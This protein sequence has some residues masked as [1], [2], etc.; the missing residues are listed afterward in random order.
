M[1][2]QVLK[3]HEWLGTPYIEN[4]Q[5]KGVGCDCAGLLIGVFAECGIE[6]DFRKIGLAKALE[7]YFTKPQIPIQGDILVF[8]MPNHE[9]FHLGILCADN[10]FIHA[11]W[12]QGVVKNTFGN[13]FKARFIAAYR[14][15]EK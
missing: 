5:L 6:D 9:A 1:P 3:A 13:W 15:L 14:Y 4:A 8:K 7:K 2:P 12:S 11:H 10:K